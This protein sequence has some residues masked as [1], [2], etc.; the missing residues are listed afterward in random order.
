MVQE[1]IWRANLSPQPQRHRKRN[2]RGQTMSKPLA[3]N[4]QAQ[5]AMGQEQIGGNWRAA[6]PTTILRNVIRFGTFRSRQPSRHRRVRRFGQFSRHANVK[7]Q[8][9]HSTPFSVGTV[10]VDPDAKGI[11]RN[12]IPSVGL[13]P[14]AESR[15]RQTSL[16]KLNVRR[17]RCAQLS[18]GLDLSRP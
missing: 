2:P 9:R 12:Q 15:S 10:L 1:L 17:N 14:C 7:R 4:W 6:H 3:G 5:T 11:N 13:Q 16:Q 18:Y 8:D